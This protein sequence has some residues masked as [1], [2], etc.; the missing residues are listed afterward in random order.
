MNFEKNYL[1]L[2][3][4][5]GLLLLFLDVAV[6]IEL[7]DVDFG[8]LIPFLLVFFG[9]IGAVIFMRTGEW[10]FFFIGGVVLLAGIISFFEITGG[11]TTSFVSAVAILV[12]IAMVILRLMH[13]AAG[14][15]P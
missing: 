8:F 3:L 2:L 9:L 7:I 15:N 6:G 11:W 13:K 12:S 10:S 5:I 4:G 14:Y 1:L